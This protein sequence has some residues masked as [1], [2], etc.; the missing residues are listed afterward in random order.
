MS[1]KS[2]PSAVTVSSF[3]AGASGGTASEVCPGRDR[4]TGGATPPAGA[5]F[6]RPLDPEHNWKP[7]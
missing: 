7:N 2:P 4:T 3:I 5:P 6:N 1:P